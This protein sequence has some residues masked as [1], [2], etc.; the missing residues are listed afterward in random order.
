M[1]KLSIYRAEHGSYTEALKCGAVYHS[2]GDELEPEFVDGPAG[3]VTYLSD[4]YSVIQTVCNAAGRDD[5]VFGTVINNIFWELDEL[6]DHFEKVNQWPCENYPEKVEKLAQDAHK[7]CG[8]IYELFANR[9]IDA[10]DNLVLDLPKGVKEQVINLAENY[11]YEV[12]TAEQQTESHEEHWNDD[13]HYCSHGIDANCCPA[14]CGDIDDGPYDEM[15]EPSGYN[16]AGVIHS[17]IEGIVGNIK[18]GENISPLDWCML[19]KYVHDNPDACSWYDD[20]FVEPL[21]GS[22]ETVRS[23]GELVKYLQ[24]QILDACFDFRLNKRVE[25]AKSENGILIHCS[26]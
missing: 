9:Y 19:K 1:C 16:E 6:I 14:G 5:L 11:G 2:T 7:G 24:R 3:R 23:A 13:V 4:M 22:R 12:I 15:Q 21:N 17:R 18:Q 25:A 20:C 10:I 26:L 8:L